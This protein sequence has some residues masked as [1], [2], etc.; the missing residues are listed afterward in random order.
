MMADSVE[1]P[2]PA[3][4]P[5]RTRLPWLRGKIDTVTG[6]RRSGKTFF[7]YQ[8]IAELLRDGAPRESILYL[9]FEDERLLPLGT[10]DLHLIPETFYRRYPAMKRRECAFF[11]DEIQ[12]V[13]G[14]ERFCRRLIDTERVHLCLTGSSSRLLGR[15][16]ATS[17][18]GRAIET[19]IFPFDFEE[20]LAHAGVLLAKGPLPGSETVALVENKFAAYLF[21]GGFPEVQ[22]MEAGDRSR[23]L[24]E[25]VDVVLLR[26]VIERHRVSNT[27]A[28]RQL[29]RH[30]LAAPGAAFSVHKFYNDLR[31]RGVAVSKDTLHAALDHLAEAFL[32]FTVA[33]R[34][35]SERARMVNP[36]KVYPIDTGLARALSR[37]PGKDES[38]LLETLVFLDLR[39][40]GHEVE[41]LVTASGREVDFAS[42]APDG[43]LSLVQVCVSLRD[44]ETRARE[45]AA[46]SEAMV[47]HKLS[48]GT[49]VTRHEAETIDIDRGRIR[50][51]PAWRF[52]LRQLYPLEQSE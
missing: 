16:I 15:E 37:E 4:T 44:P 39:R 48:R 18:R 12:N 41:Y 47:E 20:A 27:T 25:Y 28:L 29:V 3:L 50:V 1:R 43:T 11:F 32:L 30:L 46:L 51:V 5:R 40:R 45:I 52:L 35:R 31:S 24:Q 8:R 2:L 26:D 19:E 10:A 34:S 38:R 42:T 14:W 21:E 9:S 7:L 17:L 23:V 13:D 49:V 36:R 6:M 22:G 33:I